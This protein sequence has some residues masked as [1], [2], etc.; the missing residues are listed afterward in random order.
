MAGK[1]V[2]CLPL[3]LG[4]YIV[5]L[6]QLQFLSVGQV[7]LCRLIEYTHRFSISR[8]YLNSLGYSGA[9]GVDICPAF[10]LCYRNSVINSRRY[11]VFV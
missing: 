1:A 11:D 7:P 4:L 3:G 2:S 5:L 9:F 6:Q 8:R 10:L